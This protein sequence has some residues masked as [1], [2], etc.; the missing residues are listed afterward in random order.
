MS[1]FRDPKTHILAQNRGS[2]IGE[3]KPRIG[4]WYNYAQVTGIPNLITRDKFGDHPFG[5][6][7]D[8]RIKFQHFIDLRCRPQNTRIELIDCD[9]FDN[10]CSESSVIWWWTLNTFLLLL[11]AVDATTTTYSDDDGAGSGTDDG[12]CYYVHC[13]SK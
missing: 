3:R 5:G 13:V 1:F 8:S 10:T 7:G 6:F 4:V 2:G 12:T 9:R 11:V